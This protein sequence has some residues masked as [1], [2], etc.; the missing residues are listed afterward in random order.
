MN[1]FN[2]FIINFA[3]LI[4]LFF[5]Y[6]K[7]FRYFDNKRYRQILNGLIFGIISICVMAYPFELTKGLIFDTRS[8]IISI[9]GLF[10][11]PITAGIAAVPAIA[12][13][14]Y[15]GGIGMTTGILT[16]ITSAFLGAF[17]YYLR[18]KIPSIMNNLNIYV[19]GLLV[20]IIVLLCMFALPSNIILSTIRSIWFPFIIAYPL[21]SLAIINLLNSIEHE[22]SLESELNKSLN[23]YQ[24][25]VDNTN[26]IIIRISPSGTI[27]FINKFGQDIF[28]FKEEELIGKNVTGTI[29]PGKDS[30]G[31]DLSGLHKSIV[32]DPESYSQNE[33]ENMRKDGS[34]LWVA[35]SNKPVYNKRGK[36]TEILAVGVEITR[37]KTLEL[38][39]KKQNEEI[40][41]LHKRYE[42]AVNTSKI[43]I[44][45][46]DLINDKLIWDES[47]YRLYDIKDKKTENCHELWKKML[48]PD[49][50]ERA[51]E[52]FRDDLAEG[53]DYDSSFR[54]IQADGKIR[55]IKASG[56][57]FRDDQGK[58]MSVLGIDY[59]V[60]DLIETQAK[61]KQSEYDYRMLF[62][63]M[64]VGFAYH[65]MI[66]DKN[67]KACD[68]E[69]I[70]INPAFEKMTGISAKDAIGKT[71]KELLPETE[72][73]WIEKYGEVAKTEKS[74]HYKNYSRELN[75]DFAVWAFSPRKDY[76]AVIVNDITRQKQMGNKIKEQRNMFE[77]VLNA[78]PHAFF[79]K[80]RNCAYLGANARFCDMANLSSA[81]ELI[82]KNDCDL[83][84]HE[85]AN[86]F[87]VEDMYVM[88]NNTPI[89]DIVSEIPN[90]DNELRIYDVKKI[91][92]V[93]SEE[94]VYGVLGMAEDVTERKKAEQALQDALTR[95]ETAN[96][97][98]TEFLATMSHEIRTPL[99]GLIGF[100]GII[101]D[102]LKQSRNYEQRDKIIE[103]L[104]I[105]KTCG[106]NVTELINDIL[107]LASI[108]GEETEMALNDFSPE[109]LI[110]ESN[111]ILD[112][113]AKDKNIS[114]TFEYKNLPAKVH[115]ANRQLRQIIFNLVGNAIKFTAKGSVNL[116]ADYKDDNLLIEIK[117]TGIGI[118]P[119]MKG[120]ILEPFTQ[121][122]QS[123]TRKHGGTG[124]GLTIVSRI[125]ENFGS[126]LNIESELGKGTT[127]SFNFPVKVVTDS[128]T[129]PRETRT[130][131]PLETIYN[132][133]VIE[134]D[135]ISILYLKEILESYGVKYQI[136]RSFR[137]MQEICGKDFVPTLALI[138]I[139]LPGENG[140]E[141]M[142]WLKNNFP[143]KEIKCI[144][145]TAHVLEEDSKHYKESGFDDFI[146]K[147]YKKEKLIELLGISQ[148][149]IEL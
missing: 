99:N 71:V 59:D 114:L 83:I 21:I 72:E 126:Q 25:L 3:L 14:V 50:A 112:F 149:S 63:N 132:I 5:A 44:W 32:N 4:V 80:D 89:Y 133:L 110:R 64:T 42:L 22:L 93:N 88:E 108:S 104:D 77:Q 142:K 118:A 51:I 61:L 35:W 96:K 13:R 123:S 36:I 140:F 143:D 146:G 91:P 70:K 106:R 102:T 127:V 18:K 109:K 38:K 28:G 15:Q 33:N 128:F 101:E 45:E 10:G 27:N 19:F 94:K 9:G 124:L 81:K 30:K 105:V 134:D 113:K 148:R 68:Y 115:G 56:K 55:N 24:D 125:L 26:S 136:A 37:R 69:F 62:D 17:Y 43:G 29:I 95:A 52:K 79:W 103:Y 147:P 75:K 1:I 116:K 73:Y 41:I 145:Q 39:L 7:I 120:K 121:V 2:D 144:A 117:D 57:I 76:F 129:E 48:H 119:E 86:N 58:A 47:M 139:S 12:Y 60:T 90:S 66:Y 85:L 8:I 11:G 137:D 65:K 53:K 6:S 34:R 84:W 23:D 130:H 67:G 141:C 97:A 74:I 82:G 138:D 78:V 20:H 131:I 49:D 92:L 100:S 122:D 98:K 16:I 54:I 107:E 111:E 40:A 46:L 135:E 31:L 87:S